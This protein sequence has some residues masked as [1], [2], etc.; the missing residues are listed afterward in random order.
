MK[1]HV[2]IEELNAA[3]LL[4]TGQGVNSMAEVHIARGS[5]TVITHEDGELKAGLINIGEPPSPVPE[6]E[7]EP[8][9]IDDDESDAEE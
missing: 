1:S 5:V 2:T 8:E 7:P 9:I 3:L 6:P 4:L